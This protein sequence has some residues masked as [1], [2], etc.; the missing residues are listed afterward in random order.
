VRCLSNTEEAEAD[1]IRREEMTTPAS[2]TTRTPAAVAREA[3]EAVIAR[4]PDA[5]VQLAA[6]DAQDDV[7]AVGELRGREEIRRF[8]DEVFTAFPDFAM[9]IDRIVSDERTAVVQWHATGTFNGG[10]FLGILPTGRCVAL[11]GVDVMEIDAGL[12]R[13]NTIYYDGATMARQ[14]G[15]LPKKDSAADRALLGTF[16]LRTRAA[17]LVRRS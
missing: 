1:W 4:D 12:I 14:V 16:N 17:G 3:F 5:I 2:E 6:P 13:R 9:T 11:K 10:P 7:V 15:L 8:F